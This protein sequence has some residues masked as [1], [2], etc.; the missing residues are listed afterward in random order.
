[1]GLSPRGRGN[2]FIANL[3]RAGVG[4]LSPRGRGNRRLT[5][6]TGLSKRSIPAW[7]G[8]PGGYGES[9]T[10]NRVYPR[11]GGATVIHSF[12]RIRQSGLSPRGRGNRVQQVSQIMNPGS[13]PAWAGQPGQVSRLAGQ[14]PVYPR[15]GGAT[16]RDTP[17]ILGDEGLSPR[18]RGNPVVLG[19]DGMQR[20][21]IPA[22]AGQPNWRPG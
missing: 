16:G 18:G 10:K 19:R 4:G 2:Q 3:V 20:G 5:L 9:A 13:I 15:V 6:T 11:V 12:P 8:Q 1:M 17:V 7:A 14:E 22:W 21:S